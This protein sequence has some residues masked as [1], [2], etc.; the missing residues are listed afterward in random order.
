M[1]YPRWIFLTKHY[2]LTKDHK[3]LLSRKWTRA[4]CPCLLTITIF[5][6]APQKKKV[7]W[8]EK[9]AGFTLLSLSARSVLTSYLR[10]RLSCIFI[11]SSFGILGISVWSCSLPCFDVIT[12]QWKGAI[13][14]FANPFANEQHGSVVVVAVSHGVRVLLNHYL[15]E[16]T[17]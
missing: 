7:R 10:R 17:Q 11:S 1:Q 4:A 2:T 6:E 14:V 16:R 15:L 9:A 13:N 12:S 3:P 8:R 5:T